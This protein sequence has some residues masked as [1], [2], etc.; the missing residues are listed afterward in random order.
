MTRSI[1]AVNGEIAVADVN[2]ISDEELLGRAVRNARDKRSR[3][4]VARWAIIS[5]LFALGSTYSSQLCRRFG[6]DPDEEVRR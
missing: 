4:R 6:V 2:D 3:G 1:F 5:D